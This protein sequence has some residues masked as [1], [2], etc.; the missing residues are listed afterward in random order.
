[1]ESVSLVP[2]IRATSTRFRRRSDDR[3]LGSGT[4]DAVDD[5]QNSLA[6]ASES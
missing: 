2:L 3:G 5:R 6:T 1:M 4:A